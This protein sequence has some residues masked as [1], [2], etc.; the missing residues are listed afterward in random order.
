VA[1]HLFPFAVYTR[2]RR[3]ILKGETTFEAVA[4]VTLVEQQEVNVINLMII[5]LKFIRQFSYAAP[6]EEQESE[7]HDHLSE[8][9]KEI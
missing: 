1:Q 8:V 5:Y 2:R 6:E 4:E 9:V 3:P 7:V